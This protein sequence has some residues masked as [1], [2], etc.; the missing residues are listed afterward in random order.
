MLMVSNVIDGQLASSYAVRNPDKLA[1]F[2]RA[3]LAAA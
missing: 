2:H 1:A 3:W